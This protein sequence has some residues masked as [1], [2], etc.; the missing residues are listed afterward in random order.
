MS[1]HLLMGTYKI[2]FMPCHTE[3]KSRKLGATG[4]A[5]IIADDEAAGGSNGA[6]EEDVERQFAGVLLGVSGGGRC[7]GAA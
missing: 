7:H 4:D 5:D 3:S 2:I 6:G 1:R